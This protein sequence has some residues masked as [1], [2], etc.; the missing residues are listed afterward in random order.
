MF[1]KRLNK[2][3]KQVLKQPVD[4][5]LARPSPKNIRLW[6]FLFYGMKE[7]PYEGGTY[8]GQINFPEDYPFR[9]PDILMIT[10]SGR[11][12]PGKNICTSFTGFHPESW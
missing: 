4:C 1:I 9:P 2:E 8:L 6:Y 3:Y 11:F 5:I 7:S 12:K 10:P